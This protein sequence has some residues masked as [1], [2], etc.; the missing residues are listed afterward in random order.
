MLDEE[1]TAR[2]FHARVAGAL[3]AHEL[4]VVG[5]GS[6][7]TAITGLDLPGHHGGREGRGRVP[8][9]GHRR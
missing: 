9:R 5:Y 1:D 6:T 3:D 4:F 8:P 7:Q 2:A